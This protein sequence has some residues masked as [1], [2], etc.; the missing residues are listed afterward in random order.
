MSVLLGGLMALVSVIWRPLVLHLYPRVPIDT[1]HALSK[2][3]YPPSGH[4][5][6]WQK[7]D[8]E[9]QAFVYS[10][11]YD[12][13]EWPPLIRVIAIAEDPLPY[14]FVTCRYYDRHD[15]H[16]IGNVAGSLLHLR[17]PNGRRYL[18]AYIVCP[19]NHARPTA[20]SVDKGNQNNALNL[21]HVRFSRLSVWPDPPASIQHPERPG[22]QT[23]QDNKSER[24]ETPARAGGNGEDWAA[25]PRQREDGYLWNLTRCFPAFQMGYDDIV[26]LAEMVAIS[27]LLGVQHFVFYV[28]DAGPNIVRMLQVLEAQGDAEVHP[29]NM[30]LEEAD[31]YY[32]GQFASINDCLY[33]HLRTS[34]FLLFADVD[35]VF[36][37][38]QHASLTDLLMEE[39]S[40]NEECGAFLFL[41]VFFNLRLSASPLP[42]VNKTLTKHLYRLRMLT[43]TRRHIKVHNPSDRSKPVVDPRKVK[44]G[45]VHV[46]Q[47][48]RHD[49]EA[50]VMEPDR[51][52]LHHYRNYDVPAEEEMMDDPFLWE[53][54]DDF[55]DEISYIL[56][57]Y[58]DAKEYA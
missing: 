23:D 14:F 16:A 12:D 46:I 22:S 33:R 51:G 28:Q 54:F 37:Q 35:E 45:S 4:Q 52:L 34:R 18:G 9:G 49:Y 30:N 19:L 26:M 38:R 53:L 58:D 29:W 1:R 6:Q 20:V 11:H 41:N 36:V 44:T 27:R 17:E 56:D 43:H 7:V 55:L 13:A 21:M 15:S 40:M 5:P 48:L 31:L 8:H 57:D 39:F 3:S 10:A 2:R 47:T 42:Q 24:E 32:A 50:C 25:T